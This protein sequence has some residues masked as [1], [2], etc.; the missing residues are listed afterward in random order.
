MIND[1]NS[2]ETLLKY[3]RERNTAQFILS[4]Q[5]YSNAKLKDKHHKKRKLQILTFINT[6]AK[7]VNIILS[8]LTH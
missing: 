5:H 2:T 4:G 3:W 7:T 1:T 6:K 8:N